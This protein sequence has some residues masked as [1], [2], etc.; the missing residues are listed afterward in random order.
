MYPVFKFLT[1]TAQGPVENSTLLAI[2]GVQETIPVTKPYKLV[3]RETQ[4][5]STVISIGDIRIGA[6]EIMYHL[7]F[8]ASISA[9][10][11]QSFSTVLRK[12]VDDH[13]RVH[14]GSCRLHEEK[15]ERHQDHA[16]QTQQGL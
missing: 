16:A 8:I 12:N 5:E 4:V 13:N 7:F 11:G 3:S 1:D 14:R 2:D 9:I 15:Q 6:V 10:S